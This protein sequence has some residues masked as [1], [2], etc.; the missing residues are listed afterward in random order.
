MK[1]PRSPQ[2]RGRSRWRIS[3]ASRNRGVRDEADPRALA[4]EQRIGADRRSLHDGGEVGDAA[5]RLEPRQEALGL[6]AALRRR[7]RRE[8]TPDVAV[9]QHEVGE[10]A[11]DV[12]ADDR[13]T[14][15]WRGSP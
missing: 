9:K 13:L 6:V 12:D 10:S 4:F 7:L 2:V 8:E 14:L 11:A 5:E 15:H 3:S 1:W